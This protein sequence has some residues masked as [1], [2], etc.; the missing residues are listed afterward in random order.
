MIYGGTA[1]V[2][3]AY[4]R[5]MYVPRLVMPRRAPRRRST[6]SGPPQGSGYEGKRL[7]EDARACFAT[8][9][10]QPLPRRGPRLHSHIPSLAAS[11]VW[12]SARVRPA[13]LAAAAKLDTVAEL[14][15]VEVASHVT[16]RCIVTQSLQGHKR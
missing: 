3:G 11:S 2:S 7:F 12:R 8:G 15:K 16:A 6:S 14:K 13:Q 4:Y 10:Q 1:F 9:C 5:A